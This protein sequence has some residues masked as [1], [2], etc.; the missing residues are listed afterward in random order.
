MNQSK[1]KLK[2]CI[3]ILIWISL[4]PLSLSAQQF[5][6]VSGT[7]TDSEG[8]PVPGA[9]VTV[10]G[11]TSGTI[12]DVAGKYSIKAKE[13]NILVFDCLGFNPAEIVCGKSS[14]INVKFEENMTG[15]NEVVVVGFGQQKKATLTGAISSIRPDDIAT[16]KSASLAVSMAGKVPGLQ[17]KQQNGM[18]GT[19]STDVN[20]RGLGSPLYVIDGVIRD[21]V[22][23]FQM[24]SPEDIESISV[25]KDASAAI[26]GMNSG[27]GVII[28]KTRT[29]SASR[30]KVTYGGMVGITQPS[31]SLKAMNVYQYEELVNEASINVGNGPAY[32]KDE[33]AR[34]QAVGTMK[35]SSAILSSTG[36]ASH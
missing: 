24:L 9:A 28:V 17:I 30:L 14:V 26:F 3:L 31:T 1:K 12:T 25:L 7:V 32:S 6:E 8:L 15:L 13:G 33:L 20:V 11:T 2:S 35:F 36:I 23:E 5:E 22:R 27:N 19:Y 16:T 34:R 10:K 18:P 4:L 29:G 21:G